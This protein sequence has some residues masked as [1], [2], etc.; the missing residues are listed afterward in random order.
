MAATYELTIIGDPPSAPS[1][2]V[3]GRPLRDGERV[4]VDLPT[5]VALIERGLAVARGKIEIEAILK[6]RRCAGVIIDGQAYFPG[7]TVAAAWS[8]AHNLVARGRARLAEGVRL[9]V[10]NPE[11][12]K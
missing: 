4:A 7:D 3:E 8:V 5:A 2:L 9:P 1:I 10:N 6:P 11:A 12:R